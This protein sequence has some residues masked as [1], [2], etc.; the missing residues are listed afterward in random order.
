[1]VAAIVNFVTARFEL[2][3]LNLLSGLDPMSDKYKSLSQETTAQVTKQIN[4]VGKINCETA[5]TILQLL[6][7][8]E[9]NVKILSGEQVDALRDAVNSKLD[10]GLGA[11]NASNIVYQKI[12]APEEWL[13]QDMLE[14]MMASPSNL[15]AATRIRFRLN[16]LATFFGGGGLA[17]PSEHCAKDIVSLALLDVDDAT[18]V[19]EGVGWVRVFKAMVKPLAKSL[20]DSMG[21]VPTMA[22]PAQHK[23]DSPTWYSN[24]YQGK[25]PS[26]AGLAHI[27]KLRCIRGMLGCRSTRRGADVFLANQRVPKQGFA[28]AQ[29]YS[30]LAHQPM[31]S[32]YAL[33]GRLP[34]PPLQQPLALLDDEKLR[35][36][37][38]AAPT[39]TPDERLR[40]AQSAAPT[41]APDEMLS[42]MRAAP[43]QTPNEEM[44]RLAQHEAPTQI[45]N[46]EKLVLAQ[47]KTAI[48]MHLKRMQ[49]LVGAKEEDSNNKMHKTFGATRKAKK[50]LEKTNPTTPPKTK[51]TN[52]LK[53]PA[54]NLEKTNPTTPPKT[55]KTN[56]L[57]RPAAKTTTTTTTPRKD[58][59][60]YPGAVKRGPLHFGKSVV[61]FS[62]TRFRVMV[63][64]GDRLDIAFNHNLHGPRHAWNEVVQLLKESNPGL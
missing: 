1:M 37:Q 52:V 40:L 13:T 46:D 57:K 61:Y 18:L 28:S 42:P 38:P 21:G 27:G 5:T 58:S 2:L 10:Q 35:L 33:M 53:R 54:A 9:N 4:S 51:K 64:K 7:E 56:V 59:L 50:H 55:K 39:Q 14:T 48:Q 25:E 16:I 63:T 30:P 43:T 32:Q 15:N 11:S 22:S 6:T 23:E 45:P 34:L 31:G 8:G 20:V 19:S 24:M 47:P 44:L 49:G 26:S 17:R 36:A 62:P 29:A 3:K 12:D 60:A 41:G